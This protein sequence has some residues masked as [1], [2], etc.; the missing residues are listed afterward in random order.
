MSKLILF[1]IVAPLKQIGL[2]KMSL[3]EDIS[4]KQKQSLQELINWY[5]SQK[6]LAHYMCVSKQVVSNWVVRGRIS[7]KMA[8]KADNLTSGEIKKEDLRPDV[9]VW[10]K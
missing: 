8:I 9:L 3:A 10:E 4:N 5:G 1:A 7:A 6:V 2:N